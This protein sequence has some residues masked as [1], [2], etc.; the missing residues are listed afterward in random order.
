[1]S[2]T[3]PRIYQSTST[4]KRRGE[5]RPVVCCSHPSR[6]ENLAFRCPPRHSQNSGLAAAERLADGAPAVIVA[7][8][9]V[10]GGGGTVAARRIVRKGGWRLFRPCFDDRGDQFPFGFDFITA[11]KER[12]IAL[13]CIEQE[14]LI[15]GGQTTAEGRRI[16]EAH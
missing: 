2:G 5:Q 1:M 14:C 3:R 6:P 8:Q 16:A 4:V 15:G 13:H 9:Q 10:G 11:R 12:R 7:G